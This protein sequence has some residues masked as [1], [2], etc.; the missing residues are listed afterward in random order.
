MSYDK[1]GEVGER[2]KV[3]NIPLKVALVYSVFGY[4][5]IIITDA[6][7]FDPKTLAFSVTFQL[8]LLKGIIFVL[9]TSLILYYLLHVGITTLVRER[10]EFKKKEGMYRTLVESMTD[11][12]FILDG[13]QRYTGVFGQWLKTQAV[14]PEAFIGKT[15]REVFGDEAKVH[16]EAN[17]KA[18]KGENVTYE[19][20]YVTADGRKLYLQTS[21][22]PL[23]DSRGR[24]VG[25]V[26]VGRDITKLKEAEERLQE[27]ASS[28]EKIL[29]ERTKQLREAE[30]LAAI[31]EATMMVGHDLRNPL[32]A[33]LNNMYIIR[34]RILGE[35][36][37]RTRSTL[38]KKGLDDIL[39]RVENEIAYMNKIVM[40]L[41]DYSKPIVPKH[42]KVHLTLLIEKILSRIGVPEN[43]VVNKDVAKDVEEFV[44][45]EMIIE[46]VLYN[47]VLNAVQ[48]MPE[49]GTLT[50]R[51][52]RLGGQLVISVEDTGVGIP[53]NVLQKLFTPFFTTKA[54]GQGLGLAV[55]KRFIEALNGRIDVKS[56][57]GRGSTFTLT[58]PLTAG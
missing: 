3:S 7:V 12:V 44:C 48:A 11:V 2:E 46:R 41:H 27:Y 16:E 10:E 32:Q 52:R 33:I 54:K 51:G 6:L 45:D 15:V 14:P 31:C 13:Q 25:I 35:L 36:P 57:V 4:S 43:I 42:G 9:I 28:L 47:L 38:E 39:K 17:A 23:R 58:I 37:K 49:G 8:S 19:W 56:E 26:G 40:D 50:I 24:V 5:W 20:S 21:L 34:S 30:R 55:C 22:S 18:L 53:E 1:G 29:E